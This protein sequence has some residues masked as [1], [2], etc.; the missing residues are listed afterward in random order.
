MEEESNNFA[1][2]GSMLL[3]RK[4][5]AKP[6]MRSQLSAYPE[7][8]DER[9]ALEDSFGSDGDVTDITPQAE[10]EFEQ[11]QAVPASKPSLMSKLSALAK[12]AAKPEVEAEVTPEG[13][14][15]ETPVD[16]QPE[17]HRQREELAERLVASDLARDAAAQENTAPTRKPRAKPQISGRRAAFTLRLDPDRHLKLRLAATVSGTSAQQLVTQALDQFLEQMPEIEPLIES[18]SAQATSDK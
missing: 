10:P 1:S 11:A 18:L 5:A 15:A 3:V 9:P 6:A 8:G 2:L 16:A 12:P 13:V 14:D 7:D 17:V 4:G